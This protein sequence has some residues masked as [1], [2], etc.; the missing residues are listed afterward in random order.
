MLWFGV[1]NF[2]FNV[3]TLLVTKHGS[4][5][6]LVLTAALGLPVVNLAFSS[7]YLMGDEWESMGPVAVCGAFWAGIFWPTWADPHRP[8]PRHARMSLLPTPTGR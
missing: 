7:K 8:F 2:G 4:A 1:I 3:A 5:S 6:L